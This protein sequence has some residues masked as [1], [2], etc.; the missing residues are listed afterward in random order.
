MNELPPGYMAVDVAQEGARAAKDLNQLLRDVVQAIQAAGPRGKAVMPALTAASNA[1]EPLIGSVQSSQARGASVVHADNIK[2][3]QLRAAQN[4][5]A[6]ANS[7]ADF[8]K[9]IIASPVAAGAAAIT[10]LKELEKVANAAGIQTVGGMS[11][12]N[13][14]NGA[15]DNVGTVVAAQSLCS[16]GHTIVYAKTEQLASTGTPQQGVAAFVRDCAYRVNAHNRD[17][18]LEFLYRPEP[19]T[20]VMLAT[21][22]DNGQTVG[23]GVLPVEAKAL[24]VIETKQKEQDVAAAAIQIKVVQ[25]DPNASP[26]SMPVITLPVRRNAAYATMKPITD[27]L[28]VAPAANLAAPTVSQQLETAALPPGRSRRSSQQQLLEMGLM[29][30]PG[31]SPIG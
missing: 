1:I 6:A 12:Q 8:V 20:P 13:A 11:L 25:A 10:S 23:A 7:P 5:G 9:K 24:V 17:D 4:P 28:L 15:R 27:Q 30:M 2:T 21:A 19:V 26:V 22:K 3:N 29:L 14:M 31:P 18:K 16:Q